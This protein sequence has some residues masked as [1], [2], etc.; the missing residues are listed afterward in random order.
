MALRRSDKT[1]AVEAH[2]G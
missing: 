1:M 2:G